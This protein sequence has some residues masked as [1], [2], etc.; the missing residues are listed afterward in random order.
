M[1]VRYER[2]DVNRRVVVTFKGKFDSEECLAILEQH[3]LGNVGNYSVL[4]DFIA[5]T[6]APTVSDLRRFMSVEMSA[7]PGP[8]GPIA[9][10]TLDSVLYSRV[11][12]YAAL[13]RPQL[14][15]EVFRDRKEADS[16]LAQSI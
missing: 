10:V 1:A 16:W 15:I 3:R 9:I 13:G 8:R 4:Y 12:T 11:C 14:N 5:S 2:D 7:S 6:G